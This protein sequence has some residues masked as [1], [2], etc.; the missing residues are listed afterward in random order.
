VAAPQAKT[1][2]GQCM[3][4]ALTSGVTCI[5]IP[6]PSGWRCVE[7]RPALEHRQLPLRTSLVLVLM[8][9]GGLENDLIDRYSMDRPR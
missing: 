9:S 4:R 7:L 1:N 2:L 6:L 8:P 3:E 5:D